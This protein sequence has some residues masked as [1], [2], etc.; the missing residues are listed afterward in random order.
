M[1]RQHKASDAKLRALLADAANDKQAT[2]LLNLLA[3][4]KQ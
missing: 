1:G 3:G 2:V 4:T